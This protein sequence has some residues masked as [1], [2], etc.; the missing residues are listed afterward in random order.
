MKKFN[1]KVFLCIIIILIILLPITLVNAQNI[2]LVQD[3]S[4]GL[5]DGSIEIADEIRNNI[6][7]AD[8]VIFINKE[9][10]KFES[11]FSIIFLEDNSGKI[12][13]HNLPLR[14]LINLD[15]AKELAREINKEEIEDFVFISML[16]FVNIIDSN[17]GLKVE[18]EAGK[19]HMDGI[20]VLKYLQKDQKPITDLNQNLCSHKKILTTLKKDIRKE[21]NIFQLLILLRSMLDEKL[22]LNMSITSLASWGYRIS[23]K[24][25]SEIEIYQSDAC[26]YRY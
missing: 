16:S 10:I 4:F 17:G 19:M 14:T 25:L 13:L 15:Q 8:L 21:N 23:K 11:I 5:G 1:F 3:I 6:G 7:N 26:E 18:T 22:E 2:D 12:E 24:N 9:E 20:E